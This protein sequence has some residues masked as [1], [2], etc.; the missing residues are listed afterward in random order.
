MGIRAM[1]HF[2]VLARDPAAGKAFYIDSTFQA[3]P[4]FSGH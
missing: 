4:P 3:G 2:T 1:N